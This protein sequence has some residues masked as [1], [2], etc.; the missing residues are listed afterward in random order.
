MI[1]LRDNNIEN[2]TFL[3]EEINIKENEVFYLLYSFN[4]HPTNTVQKYHAMWRTWKVGDKVGW[5]VMDPTTNHY[6][7][8]TNGASNSKFIHESKEL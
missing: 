3:W 1:F 2:E 8:P 6:H 7:H 4:P 5:D